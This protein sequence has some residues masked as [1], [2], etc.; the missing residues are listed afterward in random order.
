MARDPEEMVMAGSAPATPRHPLEM[1]HR[2]I[3]AIMIGTIVL[4]AL[5]IWT[6]V[7]QIAPGFA[8]LSIFPCV[9][10]GIIWSGFR[11]RRQWAF[12]FAVALNSVAVVLFGLFSIIFLLSGDALSMLLGILLL[13]TAIASAKRLSV[14]RN[15]LF[16]AWYLGMN[17]PM[18]GMDLQD[19]EM[20]AS[21]PHCASVLAIRP[22]M[23]SADDTCPS[24]SGALVL[25]ST[26]QRL[27][28][29][30]E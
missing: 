1:L 9:I 20:Y 25:T 6:M 10:L 5:F 7:N 12:P 21:C 3:S 16:K 30:E 8:W 23:L 4:L 17:L 11:R 29:E 28:P 19:G 22:T 2:Q 15:S 13:F 26:R 18:V 27:H 24:C 14:M